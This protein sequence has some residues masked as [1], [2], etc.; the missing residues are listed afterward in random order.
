M[1]NKKTFCRINQEC[2]WIGFWPSLTQPHPHKLIWVEQLVFLELVDSK[3]EPCWTGTCL[4][5]GP[6][7]LIEPLV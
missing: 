4:N 3:R 6:D 5:I 7:N 2:S 1:S